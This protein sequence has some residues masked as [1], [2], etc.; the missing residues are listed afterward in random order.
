MSPDDPRHGTEAGNEQH[1]R[2][3]EQSCAP[4]AEA[5]LIASRRRTK[6]KT[7]GYRYTAPAGRAWDRVQRWR[8][9]GAS[10]DD[11]CEH[12][13]L[14]PATVYRLLHKG[15]DQIVYA[16]T[17]AAVMRAPEGMPLT[18]I[19]ATR[20]VRALQ[21]LGYSVE[22]ITAEAGVNHDTIL[23]AREERV[24]IARRVRASIAA[25]YDRLHMT[26]PTGE[27]RQ[28]RAGI[29]RSRNYAEKRGWPPPM[30]YDDIDDAAE[31]PK[32]I[33]QQRT[34]WSRDDLAAEFEHLSSA[35]VSPHFAA[36]QLGVSPKAIEKAIE[37]ARKGGSA[38]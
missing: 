14:E 36:R 6:R 38:A 28:Y 22:R 17:F 3:G 12:A 16:R 24:F 25:A 18:T 11:I 35:G 13:Q 29:T 34:T 7:Q 10:I 30:A 33:E 21:R 31:V 23:D 27:T 2:D 5:K 20:R 26:I 32:G 1:A 37:R 19:G 9:G 15:R 8:L 4:C